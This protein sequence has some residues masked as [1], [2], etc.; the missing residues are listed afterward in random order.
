MGASTLPVR[1][2]VSDESRWFHKRGPC[3]GVKSADAVFF[4]IGYQR[5]ILGCRESADATGAHNVKGH[6]ENPAHSQKPA[7]SS[8]FSESRKRGKASRTVRMRSPRF[9]RT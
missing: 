8:L 6:K 2:R 4:G 9:G 1:S 7:H 5:N 3:R